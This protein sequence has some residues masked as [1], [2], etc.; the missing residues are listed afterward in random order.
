MERLN[1]DSNGKL[2]GVDGRFKSF[3]KD[4][5]RENAGNV[6]LK[7]SEALEFLKDEKKIDNIFDREFWS[8]YENDSALKPLKF[9]NGKT[10]EDVVEEI[11]GLI[12]SGKK[13]V[14]LHGVCGTGKSAIALNIA[15]AIGGRVSVVVPIKSLQRQYEEDY[16]WKKYL[17]SKD[18][19]KM[20][21]AM[22]TGRE[23]HDSVFFPGKSCADPF[24]P[25]TIKIAEKNYKKLKQYY[26]MNPYISSTSVPSARDLKRISVAPANP[27]W[28]P[29]L[30]AEIELRHFRD[31]KKKRFVGMY[32]KEFVFHHRKEG[33]SYYDQY[34]AYFNSDVIIFNAAKYMSEIALGRKPETEVEIIDEC[35]EFLDSLSNSVDLN[36]SWLGKGLK[37][38]YPDSPLTVDVI[39]N[40]GSLIDIEEK[41]AKALGVDEKKVWHL[42]ETKI[43]EILL[44]FLKDKELEAEIRI[45]ELN[46][47]NTALEAALG[48]KDAFKD[49]HLT[50]KKDE[51]GNLLA[52]IVTINLARN[53]RQILSGSKAF[54]FMSGTLHSE[55]VLKNI[56]GMEDYVKVDAEKLNQGNI[57]ISRTGKEI[58]C[59]YANFKSGLFSR[60]DYL[61]ALSGAVKKSSKPTLIQVNAFSDLPLEEEVN[62]FGLDLI[63]REE[64]L[65]LQR[66]DRTGKRVSDFKAGKEERL[67]TTKCS[68]GIDFPGDTCKSVVFTKYPNPDVNDTFWKILRK[69]HSAYYWDFYFDKARRSFL[70]RMYRAVRSKDDHIFVLSP[71][72]RVLEAV[73][74]FQ[75]KNGV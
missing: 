4:R 8:L 9:S 44:G 50:Y 14:F 30:P 16:V 19:K 46:Y 69:T 18:G 26:L 48:F 17:V 45:D 33:C 24:L 1:F 2:L 71:D 56:F 53:L 13:V 29:I 61:K 67:F 32:G 70:Q 12:K 66:A 31:A 38:L 74:E 25:D 7:T 58:D 65:R 6:E 62:E 28:S 68:R 36:L 15:R 42:D 72:S 43:G 60:E 21:I 5:E 73:R 20:K 51:D 59:R 3:S 34:L 22:I 37:M 11:V 40:I 10:Q 63:S 54:V 75:L 64:L 55:S 49:T 52:R 57:E 35:D 23:N 39:K 47:C 27:Y 41:R